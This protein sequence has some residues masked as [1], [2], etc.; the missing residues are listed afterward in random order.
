MKAGDIISAK[1]PECGGTL[2]ANKW[3]ELVTRGLFE[4]RREETWDV[5]CQECRKAFNYVPSDGRLF[6]LRE[7]RREGV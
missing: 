3:F 6:W 1:C 4:E 5:M 2:A 7:R